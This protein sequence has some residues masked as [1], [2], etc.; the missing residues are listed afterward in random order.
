MTRP[1]SERRAAAR[2][3]ASWRCASPVAAL[4]SHAP[5]S[6]ASSADRRATALS[7]S[8]SAS[9]AALA[10][11]AATASGGGGGGGGV[12]GVGCGMAGTA[13]CGLVGLA[14]TV[15]CA[16][17]LAPTEVASTSWSTN[18]VAAACFRISMLLAASPR[19]RAA[20]RSRFR[21]SIGVRLS[22]SKSTVSFDMSRGG[23]AASVRPP[24]DAPPLEGRISGSGANGS[25]LISLARSVC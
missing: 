16:A 17:A 2:L 11:L 1:T 12:G 8:S 7:A 25:A 14:F 13:A 10:A 18:E 3:L 24:A 9:V 20:R 23:G 4:S 19:S 21:R 5:V 22:S 15:A 6:A